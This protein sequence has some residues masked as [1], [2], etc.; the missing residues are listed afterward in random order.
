MSPGQLDRERLV[1]LCGMF[2]SDHD[3]ERANAAAAADK[4]I[5]HSGMRWGDVINPALPLPP[6]P[7]TETDDPFRDCDWC[8]DFRDSGVLTKW[9]VD[10]LRSVG[11]R[12][13]RGGSLSDKQS[14]VLAR[15]VEKCRRATRP[16]A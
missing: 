4:L 8:L 9:E 14:R 12:L 7:Q 16:A 10:F 1:K 2:G 5:R 11:I 15:L 6:E 13:A 3:G